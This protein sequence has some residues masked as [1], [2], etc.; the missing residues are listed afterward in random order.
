MSGEED[1][2]DPTLIEKI[3]EEVRCNWPRVRIYGWAILIVLALWMLGGAFEL[4]FNP[5]RYIDQA[6][7]QLPYPAT[8]GQAVW[9]GPTTLELRDVKFSDFFYADTIVLS[10]HLRDLLRHHV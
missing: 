3:E 1:P 4:R 10:A 7:A 6:F 9:T 2:K 5:K 8:V